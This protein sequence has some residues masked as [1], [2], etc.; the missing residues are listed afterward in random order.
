MLMAWGAVLINASLAYGTAC[1]VFTGGCGK[2]GST[3]AVRILHA[4]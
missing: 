1:V 4:N 3:V 2:N